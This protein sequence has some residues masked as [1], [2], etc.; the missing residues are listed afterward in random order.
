MVCPFGIRQA[1]ICSVC[2]L[3]YCLFVLLIFATPL[4]ADHSSP[5]VRC[6]QEIFFE[7]FICSERYQ[8]IDI[9]VLGSE[10]MYV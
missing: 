5:Y 8:I 9:A 10:K 1:D 7:E 2:F 4:C 6:I 3:Y